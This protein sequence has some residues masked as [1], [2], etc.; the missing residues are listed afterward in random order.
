MSKNE[1]IKQ[2]INQLEKLPTEKIEEVYD[3]A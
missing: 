2:T 1:L 3:Y